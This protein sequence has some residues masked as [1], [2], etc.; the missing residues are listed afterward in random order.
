MSIVTYRSQ[1]H[2]MSL[3]G[4]EATLPARLSN[5][6]VGYA[7]YLGMTFWP[8]PLAVLY[9][10][11]KHPPGQPAAAAAL[12]AAITVAVLWPLR[13]RRYLAVGWFWYLGTL[14]P[15]IGLVQVGFQ[16]IA[17]RYTYLPLIGIFIMAAWGAADLTAAW[18]ARAATALD[19]RGRR[20]PG[21]GRGPNPPTTPLL[22]RQRAALHP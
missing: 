21:C 13:R 20:R 14:V 15:V 2:A 12:L 22:V 9:P 11:V 3:L 1:T 18:S 10:F 16:S 7:S 19:P 4:N 5:A 17:D 6:L 8:H